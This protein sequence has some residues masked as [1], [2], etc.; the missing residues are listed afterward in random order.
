MTLEQIKIEAYHRYNQG[1][2]SPY[3]RWDKKAQ[4]W[5][6]GKTRVTYGPELRCKERVQSGEAKC[7]GVQSN[8]GW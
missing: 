5:K 7:P 6:K 8:P 4:L 2:S 1:S 3:H